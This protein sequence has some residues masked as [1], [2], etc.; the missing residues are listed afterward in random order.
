M[1]NAI[2][3]DYEPLRSLAFGSIGS[4]YVAVGTPF[5]HPVRVLKVTNLTDANLLVSFDGITNEDVVGAGGFYLYDF[6]SNRTDLGGGFEQPAYD[7]IYVKQESTAATKG[8][9]Y[10][11]VIYASVA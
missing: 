4:N 1:F 3:V 5:S 2:R 8:T 11:T 7:Q 6:T 9:V 10:I